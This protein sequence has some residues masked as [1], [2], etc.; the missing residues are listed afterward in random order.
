MREIIL[1]FEELT[2]MQKEIAVENYKNARLTDYDEEYVRE[3]E[4]YTDEDWL[5]GASCYSYV[6][7]YFD[8]DDD[9]SVYCLF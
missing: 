5:D 1:S 3:C 2:D 6:V 7:T 8:N 9:Y 4:Q